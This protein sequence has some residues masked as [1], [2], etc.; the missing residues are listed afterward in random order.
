MPSEQPG[1]DLLHC[2]Q[3]D[4]EIGERTLVYVD[5]DGEP[6]CDGCVDGDIAAVGRIKNW[7]DMPVGGDL[8]RQE[9]VGTKRVPTRDGG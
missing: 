8:N 9:I 4:D 1:H 2:R 3:C 5:S 6:L 7:Y